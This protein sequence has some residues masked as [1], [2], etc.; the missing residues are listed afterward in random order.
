MSEEARACDLRA[1]ADRI[2]PFV[3]RRVPSEDVDDVLQEILLRVHEGF[4]AIDDDAHFAKWL[5]RVA[6]S[7]VVDHH[8]HRHRLARKHDAYATEPSAA[9]AEEEEDA[10][11]ELSTFVAA[12]VQMLPSPY[13]EALTLTEIEGLTMREAAEREGLTESGM[14]SRA[15]RGRRLLRE[16]FEA[17]CEIALDVRGRVVEYTPRSR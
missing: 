1:V 13:R 9:S 10:A 11:A 15:Q 16:L 7:V 3:A 8:R 17:C 12:F 5:Q 2:R 14:K 6:G 4:D